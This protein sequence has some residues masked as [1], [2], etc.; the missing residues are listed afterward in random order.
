MHIKDKE[1]IIVQKIWQMKDINMKM[2]F[3]FLIFFLSSTFSLC[4]KKISFEQLHQLKKDGYLCSSLE[5]EA[6]K[7]CIKDFPYKLL[8]DSLLEKKINLIIW[9]DTIAFVNVISEVK[10]KRNEEN[11]YYVLEGSPYYC[12]DKEGIKIIEYEGP[13]EKI[14]SIR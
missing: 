13:Y 4:E 5:K 9:N 3:L 8:I 1:M 11:F 2:F 7:D 12:I 6:Y 14:P 10:V